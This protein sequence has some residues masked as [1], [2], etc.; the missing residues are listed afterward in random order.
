MSKFNNK[1]LIVTGGNS[2][3]GLATAKRF[4]SQGAKVAITGRSESKLA[5]AVS[6][7]GG[8][9]IAK[10]VDVTSTNEIAEFTKDVV[11][12]HGK[13]DVVVA[14]AG[15]VEVRPY[16]HTGHGPIRSST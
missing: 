6:E 11:K 2:G 15:G 14:C 3:I 12:Q 16:S 7:I 9:V 13:I 5:Q 4:A 1:V 10:S 8:D